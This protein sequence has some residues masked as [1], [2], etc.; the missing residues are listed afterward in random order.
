MRSAAG[1]AFEGF[2]DFVEFHQFRLAQGHH[3]RADMGHA[4]QQALAFQAV[5]RLA[6]RATADA[7]GARQL[8]FRDLAAGGYLALDDGGLDTTE[9][10]LGHRLGIVLPCHRNF[11]L[12]QH[13]CRHL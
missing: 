12:I 13:D 9:D 3:P 7:V 4:H 6:Q 10:V 2:A 11:Q 5:D 1:H 8:R